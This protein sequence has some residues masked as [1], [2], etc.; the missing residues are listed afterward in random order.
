VLL[1]A[2]QLALWV[3]LRRD[4]LTH[5]ILP[6]DAPFWLDRG[7]TS[8]AAVVGALA[9]VGSLIAMFRTPAGD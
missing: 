8:A 2:I 9:A 3:V 6:T 7:V 5:S 4:G 1:A